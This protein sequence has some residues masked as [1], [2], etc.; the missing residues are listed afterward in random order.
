M[1]LPANIF[2]PGRYACLEYPFWKKKG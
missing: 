1:K 2:N